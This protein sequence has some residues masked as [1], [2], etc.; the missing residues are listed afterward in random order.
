MNII[1][2]NKQ[3]FK[4]FEDYIYS[5]LHVIKGKLFL[6]DYEVNINIDK[7]NNYI[8]IQTIANNFFEYITKYNNIYLINTEQL[9]VEST[10]IRLNNY[11]DNLNII[12]YIESNLKYYNQ[13]FTKFILPYHINYN[14]ILNIS[15]NKDICLIGTIDNIPFNRQN[16]INILK[17]KNINV[18]IISG[19][20]KERDLK[21]FKY[22]IIL[23]IGYYNSNNCKVMETFRCDRCVYNKMIVISD[24]KDDI[25]NY[26]L[27]DYVIF[28]DY[29]NIPDKVIEV[30]NNYDEY[31]NKLFSNFNFKEI[32]DNLFD[33]SKNIINK[34]N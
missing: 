12:D 8:F 23:N 22:K 3:S 24:M 18:D 26:Y 15:K 13:K 14:E 4:Y 20:G 9:S 6:F 2:C 27:K 31:Y 30:I 25:E 21:I 11:P 34:L 1:I 5:I 10:Q 19:F 32:E 29:N 17:K 7:N 28:T 33:I 16:I